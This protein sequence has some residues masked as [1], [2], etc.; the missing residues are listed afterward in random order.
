MRKTSAAISVTIGFIFPSWIYFTRSASV[1]GPA[2]ARSSAGNVGPRLHDINLT[3]HVSPFDVLILIM[4]DPLDF[5]RCRSQTANDIIGQHLALSAN[6]NFYD[7]TSF[8]KRQQAIFLRPCQHL[9]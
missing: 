4:E 1:A 8:I 9:D 5:F 6:G 2:E 3:F 7:S